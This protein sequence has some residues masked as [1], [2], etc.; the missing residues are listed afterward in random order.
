[1]TDRRMTVTTPDE[2]TV[3]RKENTISFVL[4]PIRN[5][6]VLKKGGLFPPCM[7]VGRFM[8]LHGN[9]CLRNRLF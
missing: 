3:K 5:S 9:I 4:C 8:H 1:M 2:G 7:I 6:M